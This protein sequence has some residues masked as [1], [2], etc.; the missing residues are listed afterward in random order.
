MRKS[1][2]YKNL[3]FF[4]LPLLIP[5]LILG[6]LSNVITEN[7]V[8]RDINNNN[9]NLL[10]Q[11]K[12]NVELMLGEMDTINLLFAYNSVAFQTLNSTL[13]NTSFSIDNVNLTDFLKGYISAPA[14]ARPYVHSIYLYIDNPNERF[15]SSS[16]GLTTLRTSLD[17]SWH[18]SLV[19][20]SSNITMWIEPRYIKQYQFE[21]DTTK[22]ITIY[23][24]LNQKN[25]AI[26]LNISPSYI[27]KLINN[28]T[29]FPAQ[30]IFVV[31]ENNNIIF[32]NRN[33]NGINNVDLNKIQASPKTSFTYKSA[34]SSFVVTQLQSERYGW[35]YISI[36]SQKALY[37]V[38]RQLNLATV[39]LLT[40]SFALGLVLSYYFTRKNYRHIS[41]IISII[42]SAESGK[43]LPPFPDRVK[44]EY[45]YIV[46]NIL[47]TFIEQSFLKV[48]LSE[49]KYR[50]QALELL[51]LQSQLNP[52]FL[53]NTL[54]TISIEN[55]SLIGKPNNVNRMIDN[56]SDIL[57]YSLSSPYQY[58]TLEE[59]IQHTMS[60]IN[61]QKFRYEDK[62]SV[63]WEYDDAVLQY[64]VIKLLIQPLIENSIYHG[65]K[66]KEGSSLIKIKFIVRADYIKVA[67]IDNGLGI[68]AQNLRLIRQKLS[69]GEEYSEHI[70]LYNT[71]KRLKLSYG[72]EFGIRIRSRYG[73]GTA[74]YLKIP[75]ILP[76]RD[77]VPD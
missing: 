36:I 62:F 33:L 25:G 34:G 50:F 57:K 4:L 55:L 77:S 17:N 37:Q 15:L 47:K 67:V 42:D 46:H 7:F 1:F 21:K 54:A 13:T 73:M 12:E 23:Q 56:L 28:L 72:E 26:I 24:R 27:E 29:I 11:V 19:K 39:L 75:I 68:T 64:P 35:K 14:S 10:K 41:N 59:E 40:L 20:K 2:F 76:P 30:S 22:V 44:D 63:L 38:P 32:N 49:K 58:V 51:A 74:I 5:I 16:E 31:D 53:F 8:K 70:G 52:H 48:Q 66:E 6:S 43:T 69:S 65:I 61:I 60:Y 71:D 3:S 9:I 45:G 18:G